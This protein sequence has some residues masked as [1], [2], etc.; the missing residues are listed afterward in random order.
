MTEISEKLSLDIKEIQKVLPHRYPFAMLDRVTEV[1]PG[2]SAIGYKNITISEPQFQGHFPGQPIMP[3]MLQ[4]E[5]AA[6]LSCIVMLMLPEYRDGYL[7]LF[8]GL[9][10]VKFRRLVVPGDKLIIS[11]ELKKF[12]FPFGKFDF[13][14]SVDDELCAEGS[15]SFAMSKTS[16]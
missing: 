7:G 9:D 12:R 3:G 5:A 13:R 16:A 2:V 15:L 11:T 14:A 8:T 10:A 1:I 6:Q 4:L